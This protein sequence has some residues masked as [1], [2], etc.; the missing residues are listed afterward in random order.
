MQHCPYH[1]VKLTLE[2]AL[3]LPGL[4]VLKSAVPFMSQM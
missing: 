3:A 1:D 2:S 4:P